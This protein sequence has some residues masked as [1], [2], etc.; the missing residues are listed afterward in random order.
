MHT[1]QPTALASTTPTLPPS[2]VKD[3]GYCRTQG[4]LVSF[5]SAF[6]PGF[7]LLLTCLPRSSVLLSSCVHIL[8]FSLAIPHPHTRRHPKQYEHHI[9]VAGAADSPLPT[10]WATPH[11]DVAKPPAPPVSSLSRSLFCPPHHDRIE[12]STAFAARQTRLT[13]SLAPRTAPSLQAPFAAAVQP[14]TPRA[15]STLSP[16][17]ACRKQDQNLHQPP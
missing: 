3:L 1:P 12:R 10:A 17:F 4:I 16:P 11:C 15:S 5:L 2:C 8:T 13:A 14:S 9:L 6:L 7:I